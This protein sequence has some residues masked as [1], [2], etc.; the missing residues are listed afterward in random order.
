MKD[1]IKEVQEEKEAQGVR[2]YWDDVLENLE[3]YDGTPQSQKEV[4]EIER[5]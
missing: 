3:N 2:E 1:K 5:E 4:R